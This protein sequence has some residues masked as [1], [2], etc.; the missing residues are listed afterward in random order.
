M[1]QG[2]TEEFLSNAVN[3]VLVE[4]GGVP[5]E[6][7]VESGG[8]LGKSQRCSVESHNPISVCLSGADYVHDNDDAMHVRLDHGAIGLIC[9]HDSFQNTSRRQLLKSSFPLMDTAPCSCG[10]MSHI[11]PLVVGFFSFLVSVCHRLMSRTPWQPAVGVAGLLRIVETGIRN[12]WMD[13]LAAIE[14][15]AHGVA[16]EMTKLTDT[17]EFAS[18]DIRRADRWRV[19]HKQRTRIPV[20]MVVHHQSDI[21]NPSASRSTVMRMWSRIR[22]QASSASHVTTR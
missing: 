4:S 6:C 21:E 2:T 19:V 12:F 18:F 14:N 17:V 10:A 20:G 11:D 5:V 15:R 3:E 13:R 9:V 8:I 22:M 7:L 1:E 16:D